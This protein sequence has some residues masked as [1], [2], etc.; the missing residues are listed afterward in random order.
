MEFVKIVDFWTKIVDFSVNLSLK[1]FFP[2][3]PGHTT[4][5]SY[6]QESLGALQAVFW[7]RSRWD[8]SK[9][10]YFSVKMLDF[11]TKLSSDVLISIFPGRPV[12]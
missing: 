2:I 3:F 11:A 12:H 8:L 10:V 4:H 5:R 6:L 7:G 1:L 9:S